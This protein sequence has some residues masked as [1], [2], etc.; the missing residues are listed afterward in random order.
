MQSFLNKEDAPKVCLLL[1]PSPKENIPKCIAKQRIKSVKSV[2]SDST[3][4]LLTR[5]ETGA[6]HSV[7]L[8]YAI[9]AINTGSTN[10]LFGREILIQN[11]MWL[12][13][14]DT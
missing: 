11:T 7:P 8:Q 1:L 2:K 3:N 12:S 10:Y 13:N 9:S 6:G 4:H 5:W 14:S